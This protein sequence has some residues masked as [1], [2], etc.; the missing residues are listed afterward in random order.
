M[1][2][3][4]ERNIKTNTRKIKTMKNR[5]IVPP[6]N[7]KGIKYLVEPVKTL[8]TEPGM[9]GY[10]IKKY[11][12]GKLVKQV[13]VSSQKIKSIVKSVADKHKKG[14]TTPNSDKKVQIESSDKTSFFQSLKSGFGSGLGFGAAFAVIKSIFGS[15]DEGDS[16]E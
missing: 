12:K 5:V 14:G 7:K 9:K 1:P 8:T 3:K 13:F 2:R 6:S 10:I 4:T 16:D 11:N 15:D